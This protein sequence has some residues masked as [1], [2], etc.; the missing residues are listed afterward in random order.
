MAYGAPSHRIEQY[1]LA[2]FKSLDMDGRVNY[3]VGCTEICFINPID[4]DD[5]ITRSAYTTIVKAAGLDIGACEVAFRIYKSVVHAEVTIE[6]ATQSLID[7]IKSPSYY[8]PW[9]IV[10][11][12]G[13]ASS[14]VCI[15]GYGGYWLDMP[16]AFFLGCIVGMLQVITAAKNP[17]YSNVLEVTASLI[18]SFCAR[19][20]ASI[21]GD[22]KYF[23]FASIAE[24]SITTIL[25]GYIVLCGSLEL[26]SKSVTAGSTRLFYAVIYSLLLGY[27][28]DVGSQ[29][30]QVIYPDAPTSTTCPRAHLVSPLWKILLVP[31]YLV[32]QAVL[33]RSRPRQILVQVIIGSAAY[34]VNYFVLQHA[35]AQVADTASAFVLGVLGHLWARFQRAF[36]F[37]VVVAGIMLLVPSGLSAQG[38]LVAGI[39]TPLFNNATTQAQDVYMENIYQSFSVGAQMIQVAVGLSVG[40]FVSALVVYPM[41][42]RSNYLFSF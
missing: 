27:G 26:Q 36:A 20:F 41:G 4:P 35:T 33:I 29:L 13:L 5:P 9:T 22:Q 12:Y 16:I 40:I 11:F 37:A 24:S 14:L 17:L 32:V 23:C 2:L 7:L 39:S 18:T 25:P 31:A 10:P 1:V 42:K 30:W 6:E 28:I 34:A 3:T 15:W 19:A 38:G 21:G 8:R